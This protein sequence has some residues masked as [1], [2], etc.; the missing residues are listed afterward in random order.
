MKCFFSKET[1]TSNLMKQEFKRMKFNPKTWRLSDANKKFEL[2]PTYPETFIIP[3]CMSDEQMKKIAS[4][5]SS[6]RFPTVVWRHRNGAVIARSSQ[7]NVGLLAWR[8]NEDELLI[9]AIA[10]CDSASNMTQ[11]NLLNNNINNNS[12]GQDLLSNDSGNKSTS[13]SVA[14]LASN[15]VVATGAGGVDQLTTPIAAA[16]Q[17][18]VS[19]KLLIIDARTRTVALANRVKGGGYEYSEYYT[20]CEI[21]FMNIENIHVIRSSFQSLRI[22]CHSINDNKTFLSQLENTKWLHHLSGIIKAAC[23]VISAIDQYAQPVLIHC[24]DGWDRTPQI[25]A[26]SKLLLDPYYRTIAG[27][28]SLIELDWLQFGH[29]FAQR[30]GHIAAHTTNAAYTSSHYY[31][32]TNERCPVFLQWLDCVYQISRQFPSAFQFNENFLLKL[33]VHSY[34][35]LFGNFLCDSHAERVSEH[36]DERSF[37]IWSYLNDKNS[38]MLNRL[39]DHKFETEVIYP[40]YELVHMQIWLKLFC[41]SEIKY[42]MKNE[43]Q[44]QQPAHLGDLNDSIDAGIYGSSPPLD[45]M[46]SSKMTAST[47]VSSSASR[48]NNLIKNA[49]DTNSFVAPNSFILNSSMMTSSNKSTTNQRRRSFDDLSIQYHH[50]QKKQEQRHNNNESQNINNNSQSSMSNEDLNVNL[51]NSSSM[52]H[53]IRNFDSIQMRSS[54]ESNLLM[55]AL[56]NVS[57]TSPKFTTQTTFASDR[58]NLQPSQQNSDNVASLNNENET[59]KNEQTTQTNHENGADDLIKSNNSLFL[60]QNST[61]TIVNETLLK[62]QRSMPPPDTP[63]TTLREFLNIDTSKKIATNSLSSNGE[64]SQSSASTSTM[65]SPTL[66]SDNL[67]INKN[68]AQNQSQNRCL[69]TMSTSTSGLSDFVE[70][71]KFRYLNDTIK[72]FEKNFN[73]KNCDFIS[74]GINNIGDEYFK[75]NLN[76]QCSADLYNINEFNNLKMCSNDK[77]TMKSVEDTSR[78]LSIKDGS[79]KASNSIPIAKKNS[80]RIKIFEEEEKQRNEAIKPTKKSIADCIDID[81]LTKTE[82]TSCRAIIEREVHYQAEIALLKDQVNKCK[83]FFN[84]L[85]HNP[86]WQQQ[87]QQQHHNHNQT[88]KYTSDGDISESFQ[89]QINPDFSNN[90]NNNNYNNSNPNNGDVAN[91]SG[92]SYSFSNDSVCSSWDEIDESDYKA[93]SWVPD[94]YV[95]HCQHCNEKFSIS[96]RKHHC[97]NCGQVFCYKCADQFSPLPNHNLTAPVRI[98]HPCKSNIEQNKLNRKSNNNNNNNSNNSSSLIFSSTPPNF[99]ADF[100]NANVTKP[101][102]LLLN[103]INLQKT[104]SNY[105]HHHHHQYTNL[106]IS[107]TLST[108]SSNCNINLSSR[109]NH[110][111]SSELPHQKSGNKTQKV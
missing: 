98:C 16:Q 42:L 56:Q 34:S 48:I 29:K 94:Y 76:N 100:F 10:D 99:G 50:H 24:S 58:N 80:Y 36:T 69:K 91:Q 33:G 46:N 4:F 73:N 5:R 74:Q 43:Q 110:L 105:H 31:N 26:L 57:S 64:S 38:E 82:D 44:Q 81:G 25:L 20:N 89:N 87:Q 40:K 97:R 106:N 39:Y 59:Q 79:R 8:L 51:E 93:A 17:Q 22:L 28:R 30:N 41:E 6:K 107:S 12:T 77:P 27:F 92:A 102:N 11:E 55:D 3:N 45:L 95:T 109:C 13:L 15:G 66:S 75:S 14:D 32:D 86:V 71:S 65:P 101:A 53:P 49:I 104:S 37:T 63:P 47:S 61:E 68:F 9:K 70:S 35:C 19:P 108:S 67:T 23:T 2:C 62:S 78:A 72:Y 60:M 103:P 85:A 1:D 83:W 84:K 54:S 7:P 18:Q 21:Q 111:E 90:N 88:D 52:Q 96:L